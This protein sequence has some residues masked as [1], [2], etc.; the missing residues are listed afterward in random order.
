MKTKTIRS[1]AMLAAILLSALFAEDLYLTLEDGVSVILHQN[2]TWDYQ[3]GDEKSIGLGKPILLDDGSTIVVNKNGTWGFVTDKLSQRPGIETDVASVSGVGV[4]QREKLDDAKASAMET[5]LK[6]LAKQFKAA[7]PELKVDE[8]T[9]IDCI[10]KEEKNIETGEVK[11][12][13]WKATVKLQLDEQGV[14]NVL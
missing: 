12:K 4:A 1:A 6:R 8:Q 3:E 13:L 2:Y 11:L 5:A 14:Q 9:L 7:V 10:Y